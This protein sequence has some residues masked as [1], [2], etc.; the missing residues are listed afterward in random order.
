[1]A[2]LVV[3]LAAEEVPPKLALM[4][5]LKVATYDAHFAERGSGDFVVLVPY[6]KGGEDKAAEL[7][8]VAKGLEL[9]SINE[10]PLKFVAVASG[11]LGGGTRASAVLL[12]AG[13]PEDV[14]REVLGAATKARLYSL[15]LDEA[16]VKQGAMLSVGSNAGR[17]QVVLNVTTAR[18][19]GAEMGPSVLKVAKTYH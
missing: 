18:V 14:A 7:V 9:K 15:A 3:L 12:H 8:G 13:F 19:I 16:L 10:R 5:M 4:V 11:E 6:A 2:L 17:P 1:M